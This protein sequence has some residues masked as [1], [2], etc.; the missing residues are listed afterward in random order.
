MDVKLFMNYTLIF[1]VDVH[2]FDGKI[3]LTI[4]VIFLEKKCLCYL[5]FAILIRFIPILLMRYTC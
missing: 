3:C 2:Q 4:H 1:S 5:G